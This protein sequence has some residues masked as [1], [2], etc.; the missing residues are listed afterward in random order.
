M[1]ASNNFMNNT[2]PGHFAFPF[3]L[4]GESGIFINAVDAAE[5]DIQYVKFDTESEDTDPRAKVFHFYAPFGGFLVDVSNSKFNGASPVTFKTTQFAIEIDQ[6]LSTIYRFTS[7]GLEDY[8][9]TVILTPEGKTPRAL[10]NATTTFLSSND[11]TDIMNKI[12][13]LLT[14]LNAEFGL[15]V[16]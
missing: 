15:T 5:E 12:N 14:V 3:R 8:A 11:P 13:D 4:G 10:V 1:S 7:Q 16:T 9:S 2:I 6:A